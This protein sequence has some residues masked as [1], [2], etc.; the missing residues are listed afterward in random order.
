M[1]RVQF[2]KKFSQ[3]HQ[4]ICISS[5]PWRLA[6]ILILK[7]P[8]RPQKRK[9]DREHYSP[10][11]VFITHMFLLY[12]ISVWQ[13]LLSQ[14]AFFFNLQ[15]VS[16]HTLWLIDPVWWLCGWL[17]RSLSPV[18]AFSEVI[19]LTLIMLCWL[20]VSYSGRSQILA[21]SHEAWFWSAVNGAD[22]WRSLRPF[23]PS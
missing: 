11:N 6:V 8:M 13:C 21:G 14:A 15:H 23:T 19:K 9:P 16:W 22:H 10:L 4:L 18:I 12:Y 20:C 2:F 5:L 1:K 17:K 7:F 3:W